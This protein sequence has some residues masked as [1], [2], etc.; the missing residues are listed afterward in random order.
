MPRPLPIS[1]ADRRKVRRLYAAGKKPAEIAQTMR[2]TGLS[3][4]QIS[5]LIERAGLPKLKPQLAEVR[6]QSAREALD[7]ARASNL[8]DLE[9][10]LDSVNAGLKID[11]EKLKDAWGMVADPAG[12][13]SLMRAKALL[14]ARLFKVHGLDIRADENTRHVSLMAAIFGRPVDEAPQGVVNVTATAS[15]EVAALESSNESGDELAFDDDGS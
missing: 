4:D 2:S 9:Q 1:E 14:L 8:R 15:S 6:A 5:G 12:A 11:T 10:M 7:N 13:S 3:V